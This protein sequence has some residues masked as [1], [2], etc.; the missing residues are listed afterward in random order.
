MPLTFEWEN[1]KARSNQ[2]KHGISFYSAATVFGDPL[3]VTLPDPGHSAPG[4]ERYVTL[5]RSEAGSLLVVVHSES[6]SRDT[7][8]II[9]ARLATRRE[10][11][12]YEESP[13]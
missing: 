12:G 1:A 4:D 6:R 8:R 9:S 3:A 10:R 5:G 13:L 7:I 2:A 11:L